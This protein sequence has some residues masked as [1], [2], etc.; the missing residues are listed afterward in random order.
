MKH[1]LAAWLM[2]KLPPIFAYHGAIQVACVATT[3]KYGSTVVSELSAMDAVQ[4]FAQH[5]KMPGH[6]R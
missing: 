2:R 4:R 6:G 5:H 1:K 3:G